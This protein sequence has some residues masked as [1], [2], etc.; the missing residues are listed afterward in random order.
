MFSVT[1][2]GRSNVQWGKAAISMSVQ[3]FLGKAVLRAQVC[4]LFCFAIWSSVLQ[5]CRFLSSWSFLKGLRGQE[6]GQAW[7]V[8]WMG[9]PVVRCP[10]GQHLWFPTVGQA[11]ATPAGSSCGLRELGTKLG[12]QVRA[13]AAGR[14]TVLEKRFCGSTGQG[15]AEFICK[16]PDGKYFSLF[17][18][19]G[20]IEETVYMLR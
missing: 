6:M 9:R 14:L 8:A 20:K 2:E 10:P 16:G 15:S 12:L 3:P 1:S 5:I 7:I 17:S 4:A 11:I 18:P 19:R 13:G